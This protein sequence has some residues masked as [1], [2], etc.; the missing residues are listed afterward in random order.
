M[1]LSARVHLAAIQAL[2]AKYRG[3]ALPAQPE[4]PALPNPTTGDHIS[5]PLDDWFEI[6][7]VVHAV[8]KAYGQALSDSIHNGYTPLPRHLQMPYSIAKTASHATGMIYTHTFNRLKGANPTP[9]PKKLAEAIDLTIA[10]LD[11][12]ETETEYPTVS[13][14]MAYR[15]ALDSCQ[16]LLETLIEAG[17]GE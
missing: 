1:W 8:S 15:A 3:N 4:L 6:C 16:Q 10:I 2:I 11:D 12:L 17:K 7:N 9:N 14:G 13:N 5:I